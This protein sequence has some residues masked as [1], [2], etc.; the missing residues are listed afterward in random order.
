MKER[1]KKILSKFERE[2]RPRLRLR[3][4]D[5]LP[6][7]MAVACIITATATY[8]IL[9]GTAAYAKKL[10]A[11]RAI[12]PEIQDY[13]LGNYSFEPVTTKRNILFSI[14]NE[15]EL[16][17]VHVLSFDEDKHTLD[18]SDIPPDTLVSCGGFEGTLAEAYETEVYAEIVS[19]AL[20]LH[21]DGSMATDVE[22]ISDC[23]NLLGG[24]KLTLDKEIKIGENIL[25]KGK[26]TVM[27]SVA[28][29][30]FSDGQAYTDGDIDRITAYHNLLIS[31]ISTLK[32]KGAV[33]WV[34]LTLNLI[35]NKVET[36]MTVSEIIELIN[37]LNRIQT[38][39]ININLI[40]IEN[41]K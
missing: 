13:E 11:L 4:G 1:L 24:V 31:L 6:L 15:E 36:D 18:I 14:T 38:E 40:T 33:E 7:M 35:V 23:I 3:R 12:T 25:S 37:L 39:N 26:R 27:G 10:V 30:I 34:S 2:E 5:K 28:K 21:L 41:S 9:S 32:E 19:M 29:I 20:S 16:C 22:T 8:M 17:R